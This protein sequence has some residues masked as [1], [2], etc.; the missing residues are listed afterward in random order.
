M[1]PSVLFRVPA[2]EIA[3]DLTLVKEYLRFKR[4][5]QRNEGTLQGKIEADRQ[6]EVDEGTLNPDEVDLR[7]R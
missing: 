7:G 6:Q 3:T 1:R 5:I 2:E 4:E